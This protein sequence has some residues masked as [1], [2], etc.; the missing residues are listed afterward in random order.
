[1]NLSAI[2]AGS[3]AVFAAD[4]TLVKAS[5]NYDL[6]NGDGSFGIHNPSWETQVIDATL[7]ALQ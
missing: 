2:T 4:S 5:W 7:A 1:M 6:L 3:N